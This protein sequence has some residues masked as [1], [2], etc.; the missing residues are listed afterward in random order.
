MDGEITVALTRE[1]A[2]VGVAR[3]QIDVFGA[4]HDQAKAVLA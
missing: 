1:T 2:R 3:K 4:A